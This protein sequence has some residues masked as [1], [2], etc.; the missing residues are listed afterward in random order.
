MGHTAPDAPKRQLSLT[1]TTD[2]YLES[3]MADTDQS[4]AELQQQENESRFAT[5]AIA[6]YERII[7][8]ATIMTEA[9]KEA[10]AAWEKLHVSGNGDNGTSDWPGW[11]AVISRTEAGTGH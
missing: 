2:V 6:R 1:P 7:K 5:S 11:D 10:L 4:H 9:E 3:S 8:A